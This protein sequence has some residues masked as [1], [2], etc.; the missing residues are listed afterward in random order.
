MKRQLVI[1]L[2]APVAHCGSKW[3]ACKHY[4]EGPGRSCGLFGGLLD[5]KVE[6]GSPYPRRSAKCHDAEYRLRHERELA[7]QMGE[8]RMRAEL[9]A[10]ISALEAMKSERDQARK[11]LADERDQRGELAQDYRRASLRLR[12]LENELRERGVDW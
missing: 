5:P 10:A 4:N 2:E 1:V 7:E 8:E 9:A 12:D 3:A 6:G 11:E